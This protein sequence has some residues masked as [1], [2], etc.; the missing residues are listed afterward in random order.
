[1]HVFHLRCSAIYCSRF[2]FW[3]EVSCFRNCGCR[4]VLLSGLKETDGSLPLVACR[5]YFSSFQ[6]AP[7]HCLERN[8]YELIMGDT[9]CT[10]SCVT[11]C[12]Y[13]REYFLIVSAHVYSVVFFWFSWQTWLCM[14][15]CFKHICV[16]VQHKLP[17]GLLKSVCIVTHLPF[18]SVKT[19]YWNCLM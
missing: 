16:K 9:W 13:C 14:E 8:V 18:V 12:N 1:M 11:K 15:S 5:N 6:T 2:V 19:F 3:C 10:L 17:F 4:D 7:Y